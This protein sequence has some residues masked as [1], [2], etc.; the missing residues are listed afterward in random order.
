MKENNFIQTIKFWK[1]YPPFKNGCEIKFSW[2]DEAQRLIEY[3][4]E[5]N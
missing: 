3:Y 2:E 1:D 4:L 5:K